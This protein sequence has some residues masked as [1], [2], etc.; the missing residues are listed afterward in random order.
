MLLEFLG[1]AHEVTGSCHFISFG[2]KNFLV[3]CGMFQGQNKEVM[4]NVDDFTFEPNTIDFMFLTHAHI[5]HSGRIPKLYNDGFRGKVYATKA[6]CDLCSIML[7][8]SGH[9]QE[10]EIEW[11]VDG[12]VEEEVKIHV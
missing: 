8:D 1:A 6:T 2:D 5:D 3:D 12:V 10:Q 9:I 7:P 4:L 11:R